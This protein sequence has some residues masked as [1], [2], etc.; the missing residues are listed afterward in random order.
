MSTFAWATDTG[1]VGLYAGIVIAIGSFIRV[2]FQN[3]SQKVVY[4]EMPECEDLFEFCEGIYMWRQQGNLEN[5]FKYYNLLI[6]M[7]RSPD[8][9]LKI[10]GSKMLYH[11]DKK[12]T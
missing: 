10:T 8:G 1:V 3:S 7:Y 9:L 6:Q 5:E 2:A 4:E 12:Q 11:V